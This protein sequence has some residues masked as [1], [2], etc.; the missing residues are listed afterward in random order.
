[1]IAVRDAVIAALPDSNVLNILEL[2]HHE[3]V[4]NAKASLRVRESIIDT[5]LRDFPDEFEVFFDSDYLPAI[6]RKSAPVRVVKAV[7]AS[8]PVIPV[9][10]SPIRFTK[11]EHHLP[12]APFMSTDSTE[13]LNRLRECVLVISNLTN[14]TIASSDDLLAVLAKVEDPVH[15]SRIKAVLSSLSAKGVSL[16]KDVSTDIPR[17]VI[18]TNEPDIA[19][20]RKRTTPDMSDALPRTH[21]SLANDPKPGK[22]LPRNL[23]PPVISRNFIQKPPPPLEALVERDRGQRALDAIESLN[24]ATPRMSLALLQTIQLSQMLGN[25]LTAEEA[26]T[27]FRKVASMI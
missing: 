12:L 22:V 4:R 21:K 3:L 8:K 7:T 18:A 2:E 9:P 23:T 20:P 17:K 25:V 14:T 6:R 24:P 19:I 13:M 15:L 1:M 5:L 11:S 26:D 10:V 27:I 16:T